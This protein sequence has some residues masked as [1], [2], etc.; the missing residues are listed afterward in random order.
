MSKKKL[1][2]L[3]SLRSIG[4]ASAECEVPPRWLRNKVNNGEVE[5]VRLGGYNV[6]IPASEIQKIKKL[7]R[8]EQ[9]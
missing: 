8:E 9:P 3:E 4:A 1:V 6:F 2:D 7:A 5:S